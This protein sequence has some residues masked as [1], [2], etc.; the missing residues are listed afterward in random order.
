[1]PSVSQPG[2]HGRSWS[3]LLLARKKKAFWRKGGCPSFIEERGKKEAPPL[4]NA[5]KK[6]VRKGSQ[7]TPLG[8]KGDSPAKSGRRG[9]GERG[10]VGPS[11]TNPQEGERGGGK[12]SL[13]QLPPELKGKG[14]KKGKWGLDNYLTLDVEGETLLLYPCQQKENPKR[15]KST[16]PFACRKKPRCHRSAMPAEEKKNVKGTARKKKRLDVWAA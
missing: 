3:P 4:K 13:P 16:R 15:G 8:I 2:K 1:V 14:E 5:P 6:M 12:E 10:E 7:S 9:G 11:T